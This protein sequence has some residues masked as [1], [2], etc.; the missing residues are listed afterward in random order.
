MTPFIIIFAPP[1]LLLIATGI[2]GE[3]FPELRT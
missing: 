1:V 2:V 3:C